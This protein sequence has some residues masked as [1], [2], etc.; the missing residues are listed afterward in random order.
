MVLNARHIL[1]LVEKLKDTDNRV[2]PIKIEGANKTL[3]KLIDDKVYKL[4]RVRSTAEDNSSKMI[5]TQQPSPSQSRSDKVLDDM[6]FSDDC[7]WRIN[8][9][10]FGR[11]KIESSRR[12]NL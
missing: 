9:N 2:N 3:S 4:K 6:L 5:K 10:N 11:L 8:K 7:E 12:F 1:K